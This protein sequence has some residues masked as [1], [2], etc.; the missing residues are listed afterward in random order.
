[1]LLGQVAYRASSR[2]QAKRRNE[3]LRHKWRLRPHTT[4]RQRPLSLS[5]HAPWEHA[6][7]RATLFTIHA[8]LAPGGNQRDSRRPA[9]F[10]WASSS[11]PYCRSGSL[12]EKKAACPDLPFLFFGIQ[13]H[14]NGGPLCRAAFRKLNLRRSNSLNH[15]LC[16]PSPCFASITP[17]NARGRTES[18]PYPLLSSGG[19]TARASCSS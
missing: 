2:Q 17:H 18:S 6:G 9:A 13:S 5:T 19:V 12:R 15:A 16:V 7:S 8:C 11:P 14:H 3:R 4:A 1:M 10:P